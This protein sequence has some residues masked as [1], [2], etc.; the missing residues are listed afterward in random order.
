MSLRAAIFSQRVAV[1]AHEV[2]ERG[3]TAPL[4]LAHMCQE[5][6][7]L[8]A[9]EL[10]V[11]MKWLLDNNLAWVLASL[12][13][14]FLAYPGPHELLDVR[15]WPVGSNKYYAFRMFH[16]LDSRGEDVLRGRSAWAALDVAKRAAASMPP[17]V[18]A[19]EPPDGP[20]AWGEIFRPAR[21]RFSRETAAEETSFP[22]RRSDLDMNGHVNNAVLAQMALES[23]PD[24]WWERA[25]PARLEIS[26]KSEAR[27][28]DMVTVQSAIEDGW[29]A[30]HRLS[31]AADG[32]ELV[33]ARS[34][35]RLR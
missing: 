16:I 30:A 22:V 25:E 5:A 32:A 13:L 12:D 20:E 21:I 19:I 31:R 3:K 29:A 26:F 6:A 24:D 1:K 17:Q 28:R 15:T 11:G 7:A 8:H 35:W 10:G 34:H 2:D 33:L 23:A 18:R 4:S 14:E 27:H 9:M